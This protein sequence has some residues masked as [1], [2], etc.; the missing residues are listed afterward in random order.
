MCNNKY[1]LMN[2]NI[3][4]NKNNKNILTIQGRFAMSIYLD[5]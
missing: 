4:N 5:L 2:N 1:K 3:S